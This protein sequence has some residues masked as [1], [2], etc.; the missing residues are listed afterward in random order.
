V[1]RVLVPEVGAI[2]EAEINRYR[3]VHPVPVAQV[4]YEP[5]A[6]NLLLVQQAQVALITREHG[7]PIQDYAVLHAHFFEREARI[8]QALILCEQGVLGESPN[9]Y[10][11]ALGFRLELGFR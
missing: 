7:R 9:F 10:T 5:I 11:Q 1:Q 6:L 2:V 8:P 3:E 4:V